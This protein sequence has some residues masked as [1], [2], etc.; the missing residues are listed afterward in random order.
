MRHAPE[1]RDP[2]GALGASLLLALCLQ[3]PR[4]PGTPDITWNPGFTRAKEALKN[5]VDQPWSQKRGKIKHP[6]IIKMV[7]CKRFDLKKCFKVM[8]KG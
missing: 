6:K 7:V 2:V 8:D 1:S 4:T 3:D 5:N